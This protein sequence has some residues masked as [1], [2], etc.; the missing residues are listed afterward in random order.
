MLVLMNNLAGLQMD[1][2]EIL[3]S[4]VLPIP[5]CTVPVHVT[6]MPEQDMQEF[7]EPTICQTKVYLTLSELSKNCHNFF[8][9]C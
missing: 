2:T 6:D 4:G 3:S 1:G 5:P 8:S 9:N 7:L